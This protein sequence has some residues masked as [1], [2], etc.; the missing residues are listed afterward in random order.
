MFKYK[1]SFF[2]KKNNE[3]KKILNNKENYLMI[4]KICLNKICLNYLSI[5]NKYRIYP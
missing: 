2:K 3:S 4:K 1:R 5:I